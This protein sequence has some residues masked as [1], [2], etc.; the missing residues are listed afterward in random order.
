MRLTPLE[1]QNMVFPKKR[2]GGFDEDAVKDF[3]TKVSRD[4]EDLSRE[5]RKFSEELKIIREKMGENA[6]L[7]NALKDALM[8]AQKASGQI[9]HNAQRESVLMLKESELKAEKM[10][11]D[12]RI[13]L[14]SLTDDVR[15]YKAIKRKLKTELRL[16]LQSYMDLLEED[17]PAKSRD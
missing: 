17:E 16:L 10:L 13:E 14:K 11:D 3:L 9:K 2:F 1:I 15:N 12:A 4:Y 6:N 7:E 8:S 5:H